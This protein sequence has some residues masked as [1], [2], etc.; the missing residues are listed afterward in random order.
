MV[1]VAVQTN[2]IEGYQ[3]FYQ[4]KWTIDTQIEFNVF[5]R[6]S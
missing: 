1:R 4:Y 6:V 3:K 5:V 2:K